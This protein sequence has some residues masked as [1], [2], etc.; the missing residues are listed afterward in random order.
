MLLLL[1]KPRH[2]ETHRP[3]NGKLSRIKGDTIG[4]LPELPE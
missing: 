4:P 3:V 2:P 1:P